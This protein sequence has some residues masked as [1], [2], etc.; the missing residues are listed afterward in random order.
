LLDKEIIQIFKEKGQV[1]LSRGFKQIPL[2]KV[3]GKSNEKLKDL[4]KM[5]LY[6]LEHE[7]NFTD[8]TSSLSRIIYD[9]FF[10]IPEPFLHLRANIFRRLLADIGEGGRIAFSKGQDDYFDKILSL[11]YRVNFHKA[12]PAKSALVY[13]EIIKTFDTLHDYFTLYRKEN[14]NPQMATI[15][16]NLSEWI[17]FSFQRQFENEDD[18]EQLEHFYKPVISSAIDTSVNIICRTID[19]YTFRIEAHQFKY[20]KAYTENLVNLLDLY[21]T[22]AYEYMQDGYEFYDIAFKL[23]EEKSVDNKDKRKFELAN[24]KAHIVTD[25]KKKLQRAI[26]A[27]AAYITFKVES[28]EIP[29]YLVWKVA[30]RMANTCKPREVGLWTQ[31]VQQV[32]Q[33]YPMLEEYRNWFD[34]DSLYPVG[35][36][37]PESY[38]LLKFWILF[39]IYRRDKGQDRIIQYARKDSK[40]IVSRIVGNLTKEPHCNFWSIALNIPKETFVDLLNNIVISQS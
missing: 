29:S 10:R 39:D 9:Q 35:W 13:Q 26:F 31:T 16:L 8:Y 36:T 18:C 5:L 15:T 14:Y 23:K 12:L 37:S 38:S 27:L 33:E 6:S 17:R 1:I 7:E 3:I 32:L 4:N 2:F 21:H 34:I 25:M 11:F 28:K 20:L 40:E 19:R 24:A 22:E 30:M